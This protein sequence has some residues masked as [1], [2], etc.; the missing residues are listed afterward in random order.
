LG[1]T[2]TCELRD[3]MDKSEGFDRYAVLTDV[4]HRMR[5][6]VVEANLAK[7]Y[8]VASLS[9]VADLVARKLAG[10]EQSALDSGGVVLHRR[11]FDHMLGEL[12]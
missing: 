2:R 7:L 10:P 9:H 11:E 12:E 5:T 6:G 1:D 3:R 8:K 4:I